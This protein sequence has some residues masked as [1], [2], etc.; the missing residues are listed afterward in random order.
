MNRKV[1]GA[2]DGA[3]GRARNKIERMRHTVKT[4]S[5]KQIAVP[6]TESATQ[7][8]Q[9]FDQSMSKSRGDTSIDLS[10]GIILWPQF[11][12]LSLAGLCDALRHAADLADQSRQV[13]CSWKILGVEGT[14][15]TSSCGVEVAVDE[16][17]EE[18]CS[19]DY[20]AVIGG[21][22]PSLTKVHAAYPRY[23]KRME[24]AGKSIMGICTGSFA[25][26]NIGLM[27]EHLACIHPFHVNDWKSMFP[28]LAYTTHCDFVVDRL[29]ITCAG[30][31]S[32][33]ELAVEL[34]RKH[35]GPDRA[36]KVVH[37]MSVTQRSSPTH[38]GRRL[39]LGYMAA[40][41]ETFSKAVLLMEK[42]IQ[43]PVEI[44]VIARLVGCSARQL[45]RIFEASVGVS[46]SEFYR[47]IRLKYAR[48]M[49]LQG[50]SKVQDIA[51]ETGFSDASHFVRQ[52][53]KL[54]GLSPGQLRKVLGAK[55]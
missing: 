5:T 19:H 3:L 31:I 28:K 34:I 40:S 42:N 38:I 11:P 41:E 21:L 18:D 33:I 23:L 8:V 46:P 39:A 2:H 9:R 47:Q 32:I 10:I 12:L 29:R 14:K 51:F 16:F 50:H 22:L 48:W 36:A 30:G 35:C 37:Q 53:Q 25:L 1:S 7:L 49:L 45:E 27:E 4:P 44:A 13:R 6:D 15:V 24:R 52:F 17:L 55:N 43:T 20:I 54:Y 26:A